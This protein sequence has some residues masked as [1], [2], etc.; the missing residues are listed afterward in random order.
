MVTIQS[1]A[2]CGR[3]LCKIGNVEYISCFGYTY[4]VTWASDGSVQSIR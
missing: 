1:L 4:I 2:V 3:T